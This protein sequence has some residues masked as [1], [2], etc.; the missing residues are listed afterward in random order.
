MKKLILLAMTV[1]AAVVGS[2]QN[3]PRFSYVVTA[4]AGFA[5]NEPA[6]TP[7]IVRFT[8]YYNVSSHFSVGAGTGLSSYEKMLIPLFAD[9][10]F[11]LIRPRR[12]T[13]YIGCAGGYAFAPARDAR[14]GLLLSPALGLQYS[15]CGTW[16]LFIEVGYEHQRIE[17]LR[18]YDSPFFT[19][20][21]VEKLNHNTLLLKLGIRF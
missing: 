8:G 7:F 9:T 19:A 21:F 12:F 17:R 6:S 5:L 16:R 3:L 4:G 1:L 11:L 18:K 10:R 13:P 2:G 14:G 20:R 15:L